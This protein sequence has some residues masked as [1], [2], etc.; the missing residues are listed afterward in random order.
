MRVITHNDFDGIVSAVLVSACEDVTDYLFVSVT[1]LIRG[2]VKVTKDDIICDLPYVP[3]CYLWFDHHR[4][5]MPKGPINGSFKLLPSASHVIYEYYG[6]EKLRK[7][8][9]LVEETDIIDSARFR[10]REDVL[11]PKG[12]ILLAFT[13]ALDNDKRY[14]LFLTKSLKTNSVETTLRSEAVEERSRKVYETIGRYTEVIR[15]KTTTTDKTA[16]TELLDREVKEYRLVRHVQ[17]AMYDKPMVL[18]AT[19]QKNSDGKGEL[20]HVT[21]GRNQFVKGYDVDIDLGRLAKQYGGGGHRTFAVFFFRTVEEYR[22]WKETV[23]KEIEDHV[24]FNRNM[25]DE[26]FA[27]DKNAHL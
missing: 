11:K 25:E 13:H 24:V 12:A 26:V 17:T 4:I 15:Q 20:L 6:E 5:N 19:M 27:F 1:E 14:A 9:R 18:F 16:I 22:V 2:K 23:L 8:K 7:Y 3:G 21:V 10:S